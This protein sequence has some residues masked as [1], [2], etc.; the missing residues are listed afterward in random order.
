M[1]EKDPGNALRRAF[2]IL[3]EN[4]IDAALCS[5][6]LSLVAGLGALACGIG[7]LVTVPV[8]AIGSFVMCRQLIG[9]GTTE[10]VAPG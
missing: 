6:V 3:K 2:E 5:L 8:A 7:M 10:A 4:L 1:G 9:A